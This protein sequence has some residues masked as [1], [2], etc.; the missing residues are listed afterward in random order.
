MVVGSLVAV[1]KHS[2]CGCG[3]PM[4]DMGVQKC[5]LHPTQLTQVLS[6]LLSKGTQLVHLSSSFHYPRL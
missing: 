5:S 2:L 1:C 4:G 6:L 3:C